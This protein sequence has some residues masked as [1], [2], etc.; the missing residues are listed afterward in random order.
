MAVTACES[1]DDDISTMQF[2]LWITAAEATVAAWKEN[3]ADKVKLDAELVSAHK[4]VTQLSS[5]VKRD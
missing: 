2:E 1:S 3:N 4:K 5:F